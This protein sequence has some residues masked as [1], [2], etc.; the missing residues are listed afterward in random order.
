MNIGR[1]HIENDMNFCRRS[2]LLVTNTIFTLDFNVNLLIN[3]KINSTHDCLKK[4]VMKALSK[5]V[6]LYSD[7][8]LI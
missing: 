3:V 5:M 4:V 2:C 6:K 7:V 8:R 1:S